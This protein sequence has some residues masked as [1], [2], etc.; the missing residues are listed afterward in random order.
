ME[1]Y[2]RRSH[3]DY[4]PLPPLLPGSSSPESSSP[5]A[6]IYPEPGSSIFIPTSLDGSPGEVV[7]TAA[8]L[9]PETEVFWHLDS[10]YVGQTRFIHS[11]SL[12][13]SRGSHTIT[14]VDASGNSASVGFTV[15]N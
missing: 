5:L 12:R 4:V 15:E 1:W 14:A 7:F 2:Y 9:N 10:E 13:P 11:L 8:H 3:P 6:F